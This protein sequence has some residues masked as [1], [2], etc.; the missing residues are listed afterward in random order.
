[1]LPSIANS[2]ANAISEFLNESREREEEKEALRQEIKRLRHERQEAK[3]RYSHELKQLRQ[4]IH[5]LGHALNAIRAHELP[6]HRYASEL[7]D[8]NT[9]SHILLLQAQVCREVH[10]MC[11]D[12]VQLQLLENTRNDLKTLAR[13][14]QREQLTK[15]LWFNESKAELRQQQEDALYDMNRVGEQEEENGIDNL[16]TNLQLLK[17]RKEKNNV[18]SKD[19]STDEDDWQEVTVD[20]L[21]KDKATMNRQDPVK[22]LLDDEDEFESMH[23]SLPTFKGGLTSEDKKSRTSSLVETGTWNSEKPQV[24]PWQ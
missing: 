7:K 16:V 1:M 19:A 8:S 15:L 12:S 3:E 4:H 18:S 10:H 24:A 2:V 5:S 22:C 11:V 6:V 14:Q 23:K 13:D 17:F 20:D 9:P 21:K